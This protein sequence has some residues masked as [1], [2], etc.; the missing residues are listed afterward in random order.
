MLVIGGEHQHG[1]E[2]G[3]EQLVEIGGDD[4]VGQLGRVGATAFGVS[5]TT[6]TA[7]P[8]PGRWA[9]RRAR[10]EAETD[11][12]YFEIHENYSSMKLS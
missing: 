3:G 1:V 6:V 8:S 12:A 2:A 7:E 4:G 9:A 11:D 5:H 10:R